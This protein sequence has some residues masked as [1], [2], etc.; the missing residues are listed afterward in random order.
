[1]H[2]IIN[3]KLIFNIWCL[4]H[5]DPPRKLS[6]NLYDGYHFCV[7]SEK[8]LMMDRETVRNM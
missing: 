8:L 6:A 5:P 3:Y 4:L 2:K 7:Y 1:M